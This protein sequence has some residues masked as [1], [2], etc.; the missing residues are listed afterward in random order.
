M[1]L[2][3]RSLATQRLEKVDWARSAGSKTS[4]RIHAGRTLGSA[5]F[6][7]SRPRLE[8]EEIGGAGDALPEAIKGRFTYGGAQ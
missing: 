1:T 5:L 3:A 2:K 6:H 4:V 7:V 8:G